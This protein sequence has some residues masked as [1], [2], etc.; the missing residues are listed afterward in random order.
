M[1]VTLFSFFLQ[2]SYFQGQVEVL[3]LGLW[4]ASQILTYQQWSPKNP[5]DF[6]VLLDEVRF[7]TPALLG[8]S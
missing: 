5:S 2:D 6:K 1:A 4:S 3:N 7:Q 8:Q